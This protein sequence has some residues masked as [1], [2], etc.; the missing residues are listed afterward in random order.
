MQTLSYILS[1][2]GLISMVT[3]SLIKGK[4]MKK[5][6]FFVFCG[7]FLVATSYLIGGNGING[8]AACYI[9]SLQT[10]INYFFD[11]KNKPLPTWLI[12]IY[13]IAIIALNIAVAG[14]I[15]WLGLLVI[16]ASLTFILCIGQKNGAKYRFWTIVNMVLWCTYDI[17]S[18]SFGALITHAVLLLFTV[19]GMFVNDIK[20][21]KTEKA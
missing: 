13:A 7:N 3:A 14:G 2:L 5:I 16:V 19:I 1:I 18:K 8:A 9:G 20:F 10:I 21:S 11:S 6:L 4:D 12:V 15:T 17:L